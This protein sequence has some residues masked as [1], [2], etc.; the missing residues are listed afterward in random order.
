VGQVG[1]PKTIFQDLIADVNHAAM[2]LAFVAMCFLLCSLSSSA[3][4]ATVSTAQD[5]TAVIAL[6]GKPCGKVV[7]YEKLGENEF[8]AHCSTG[9]VYRVYVD[10][11]GRVR[12]ENRK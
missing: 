10:A 12:I 1:R 5:L 3:R 2:R 6:Q 7:N 4:A 11:N 9:D 8:V